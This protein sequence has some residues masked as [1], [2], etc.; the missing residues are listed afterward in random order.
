LATAAS[1][2]PSPLAR[3][4]AMLV[5]VTAVMIAAP[6]VTGREGFFMVGQPSSLLE[7]NGIRVRDR[8]RRGAARQIFLV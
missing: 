2:A 4:S 5:I 3:E 8:S 6:M 1:C 7:F